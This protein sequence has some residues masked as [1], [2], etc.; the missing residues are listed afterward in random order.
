MII[1]VPN[2]AAFIFVINGMYIQNTIYILSFLYLT[3]VFVKPES[4]FL[5]LRKSLLKFLL[6]CIV[7]IGIHFYFTYINKV[8]L[9]N[10][11]I[12]I[13]LNIIIC[14]LLFLGIQHYLYYR[15]QFNFYIFMLFSFMFVNLMTLVIRNL[16]F[17]I[18]AQMNNFTDIIFIYYF[19]FNTYDKPLKFI[20]K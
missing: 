13:F 1:C 20:K 2:I 15:I 17:N 4:K 3:L 14:N 19:T 11:L 6:I 8:D 9:I 12:L 16:G 5:L 18:S 7:V 10:G